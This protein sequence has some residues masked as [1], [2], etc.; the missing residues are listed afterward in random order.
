MATKANNNGLSG[1]VPNG[2]STSRSCVRDASTSVSNLNAAP[3]QSLET[4]SE[5]YVSLKQKYPHILIFEF[6]DRYV[7]L[8]EDAKRLLNL[9][10]ATQVSGG[11][12]IF[13][14]YQ[15]YSLLRYLMTAGEKAAIV[16]PL[17]A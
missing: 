8:S 14:G 5:K 3:L 2:T 12:V 16:S 17:N 9:R 1:M 13:E 11:A 4:A 7:I 15:L 6:G 10:P